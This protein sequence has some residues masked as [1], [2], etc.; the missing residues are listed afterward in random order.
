MQK[1][2]FT[3]E[4]AERIPLLKKMLREKDTRI[5]EKDENGFCHFNADFAN[6]GILKEK[7][8]GCGFSESKDLVLELYEQ[9]FHHASFTGRSGTFYAY[10]GLGSIYWHMVSK[11]LLAVQECFFAAEENSPVKADLA[12]YYYA[13]RSGLSFNKT[14]DLYGAF[15]TDPYSHTPSGRGACQPGMTGQVKEEILTRWGELGLFVENGRLRIAPALLHKREF[16]SDGSLSFLR[17]GILFCYRIVR[18][19]NKECIVVDGKRYDGL[20]LETEP[21]K[22]LFSRASGIRELCAYIAEDRLAE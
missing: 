21:S 1:N 11:L 5:I 13:V 16:G 15:P 12:A 10:E 2:C 6:A 22:C 14:P 19:R 20:T 7:L 8:C 4:K 9:T 3:A 17:F 18:D